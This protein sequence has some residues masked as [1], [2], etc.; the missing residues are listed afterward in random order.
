MIAAL[1]VLAALILFGCVNR[2]GAPADDTLAAQVPA[3]I[4]PEDA[5]R[6][7]LEYHALLA[8]LDAAELERER[9]ALNIAPDKPLILVRQAMLLSHPR[10]VPNLPRA[11]ALLDAVLAQSSADATALH[12]LARLLADEL[13]ERQRAAVAAERLALQLERTGQQLKESQRHSEAL[14]AKL[15]ALAEIERMLP[16][17]PPAAAPSPP[18]VPERRTR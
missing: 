12:P 16:V 9:A 18:A 5:L 2:P 6:L 3:V 4:E 8:T 13:A 7:A 10:S 15:D 17:R 11:Q 14:Q 1:V